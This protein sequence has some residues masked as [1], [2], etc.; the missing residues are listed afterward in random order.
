VGASFFLVATLVGLLVGWCFTTSAIVR[1]ANA[2]LWVMAQQTPAF[3]M[4]TAIPRHRIYQVRNVPGVE[5]AEGMVVAWNYWKRPD[6]RQVNVELVGLDDS[7]VGGPW[8]MARGDLS[9][10]HEPDGVIVDELYFHLLG[11]HQI[12]DE[13]EMLARRAVVRG[14]CRDVR[15]FTASPFIFTSL[16]AAILYDRRYRD[17]EVTYVLVRCR[18]GWSPLVVQTAIV[19]EVPHVEALT[20][21][22]FAVRTMRYWMLETGAGI[23]IVITA[24]LGLFVGAVLTS[25]TLFAVTHH[26]LAEYATLLAL[27]FRR[28]FLAGIVVCQAAFIGLCGTL[29]GSMA[30][31]AAAHLS[32]GT[33]FPLEM[34]PLVFAALVSL[35]L[36]SCCLASFL[37]VR[38]VF[39]MDPVM[40][41]AR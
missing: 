41:F 11:V 18:P 40:V 20:R 16:K 25:Q 10:V 6:G 2:D 13:A 35:S 28:G 39:H 24:A 22:E 21:R 14:I 15:T 23:T 17:D 38:S 33:P 1:N 7:C 19:S 31:F 3:D 8:Q 34:T 37:S 9:V 12:G 29:G 4:G 30:Y 36:A 32:A 26:H 5:W 27:G